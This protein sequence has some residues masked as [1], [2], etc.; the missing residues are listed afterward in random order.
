MGGGI[1]FDHIPNR[2]APSFLSKL[3]PSFFAFWSLLV[4]RVQVKAWPLWRFRA[5]SNAHYSM[6]KIRDA[7]IGELAPFSDRVLPFR[8]SF[9][10]YL[11][12][13]SCLADSVCSNS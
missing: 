8:T 13:F 5:F 12:C 11:Y 1:S 3:L 10:V 7:T 4:L 9:L 2:N 6:P